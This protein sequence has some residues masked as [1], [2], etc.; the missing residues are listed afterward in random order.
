MFEREQLK[1]MLR[2]I[3]ETRKTIMVISGPRQSGKTTAVGQ[4]LDR[5]GIPAFE[6][7]ADNIVSEGNEWI[8]ECWESARNRMDALQQKEAILVIDEVQKIKGWSEAVKKEWDTTQGKD[9]TSRLCSWDHQGSF[10]RK[11]W[12]KASRGDSK[13]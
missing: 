5:C 3:A 6:Y 4:M 11:G 1:T 9:A 2:N 8:I 10:C 12:K 7:S 13:K